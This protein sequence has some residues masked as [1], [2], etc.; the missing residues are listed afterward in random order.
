MRQKQSP[1]SLAE[2]LFDVER[3]KSRAE[4]HRREVLFKSAIGAVNLPATPS[5]TSECSQDTSP[6]E[7]SCSLVSFRLPAEP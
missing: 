7:T 1:P 6:A 4:E 3:Q 5:D 2:D